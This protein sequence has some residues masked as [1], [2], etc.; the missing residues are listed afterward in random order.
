MT[1]G[2]VPEIPVLITDVTKDP[3]SACGVRAFKIHGSKSPVVGLQQFAMD[4]VSVESLRPFQRQ[5]K[6]A[7]DRWTI[8]MD[9]AAIY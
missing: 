8:E 6:I 1:L 5:I 7:E 3:P 9:D 2:Q 4:V